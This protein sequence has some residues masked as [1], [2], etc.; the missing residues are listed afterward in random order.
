M[1]DQ[2]PAI[3]ETGTGEQHSAPMGDHFK[4]RSTWL[5]LVFMLI[6]AVLLWLA[7]VVGMFVVVVGFLWVLFTGEVNPQLKSAGASLS[8]YVRQIV[9]YLTYNTDARPF[10]LGGE[11]PSAEAP[12][13]E[14]TAG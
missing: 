11:W 5:R 9:L 6:C 4:S 2:N 14:R 10:P 3:D 12:D 1:S 8:E 13:D 7:G